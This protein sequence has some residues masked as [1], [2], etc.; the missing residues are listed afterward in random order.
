M[1]NTLQTT[2]NS[3][4]RNIIL[5]SI[6]IILLAAL[7]TGGY[8]FMQNKADQQN[9]NIT[10]TSIPST[11]STEDPIDTDPIEQPADGQTFRVPEFGIQMTLPQGLKGLEYEM[12]DSSYT[13]ESGER[14]ERTSPAFT[15]R[16]LASK[17][18]RCS[19]G[20]LGLML[21]VPRDTAVT[22]G[23]PRVEIGDFII[24]LNRPHQP[25][26]NDEEVGSLQTNQLNLF[27]ETLYTAKAI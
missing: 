11:P 20:S 23:D 9:Q 25:C 6:V 3:R 15:T 24:I 19:F 18:E 5:L 26:T 17:G 12:Q 16:E 22:T 7:G 4:N 13:N 14:V 2:S 10:D 27:G 8:L 21:K 1:A